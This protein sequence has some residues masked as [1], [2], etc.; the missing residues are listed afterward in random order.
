MKKERKPESFLR[1]PTYK[2]GPKAMRAFIGENL[3]YPHAARAAGIE[4]TVRLRIDISH[5]GK[6]T[7][8]KV[9]SSLGHGCDEEAI[10]VVELLRF[11]IPKLRKLRA[12][13]H[14]TINIHFRLAA[15]EKE[16]P[17][18]GQIQYTVSPAKTSPKQEDDQKDTPEGG[19]YEYTI[20]W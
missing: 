8:T 12:V 11:E 13:F 18:T 20:S 19:G 10:R 15:N 2:G 4:G 9:L 17:S 1:K 6:V 5:Q 16:N 3:K 14:K 7:A